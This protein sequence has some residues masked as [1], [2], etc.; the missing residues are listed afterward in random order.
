MFVC[1]ESSSCLLLLHHLS[2]FIRRRESVC[3]LFLA[4]HFI[5][6]L[7]STFICFS[8]RV[9][10]LLREHPCIAVVLTRDSGHCEQRLGWDACQMEPRSDLKKLLSG[11]DIQEIDR[12]SRQ[13][14]HTQVISSGG[15]GGGETLFSRK[16]FV[17]H[18]ERSSHTTLIPTA[19]E[20]GT[21]TG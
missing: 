2:G 16:I 3:F 4:S 20:G 18:K 1:F 13:H 5:F 14:M 17:W 7:F 8:S 15:L 11:T 21:R 19:G 6:R 12:T 9:C 10:N